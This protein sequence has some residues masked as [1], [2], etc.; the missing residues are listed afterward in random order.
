MSEI[1]ASCGRDSDTTTVTCAT[2]YCTTHNRIC[3]APH[4][5]LYVSISH[6]HCTLQQS[7]TM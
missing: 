2:D 7:T 3:T 6:S 1:S 5:C 4:K